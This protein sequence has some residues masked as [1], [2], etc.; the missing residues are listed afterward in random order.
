MLIRLQCDASGRYLQ[1]WQSSPSLRIEASAL[2]RSQKSYLSFCVLGLFFQEMAIKHHKHQIT[3]CKG[4]AP[5]GLPLCR[6]SAG[7]D[8][9]SEPGVSYFTAAV[10]FS[11]T[12]KER[13]EIFSAQLLTSFL[14]YLLISEFVLL[15]GGNI[16]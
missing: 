8:S 2:P 1:W 12:C 6:V 9:G 16:K 10:Q 15:S 3:P 7:Y 14:A 5:P 11:V 4:F 13:A